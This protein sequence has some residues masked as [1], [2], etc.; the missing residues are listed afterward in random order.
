MLSTSIFFTNGL[1]MED[2]EL[3]GP[4]K[5]ES[6]RCVSFCMFIGFQKMFS[7]P[8]RFLWCWVWV[9]EQMFF[10][11][12]KKQKCLGVLR[13]H[14]RPIRTN[15]WPILTTKFENGLTNNYYTKRLFSIDYFNPIRQ[16]LTGLGVH[17]A[18]GPG[19]DW[20]HLGDLLDDV[21][22]FITT[23]ASPGCA[24]AERQNTSGSWFTK[25]QHI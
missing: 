17:W 20:A 8:W 14:P 1:H 18:L 22:G 19:P 10:F 16:P 4:W 12:K 6:W 5:F 24:I 15:I 21:I 2:A 7:G 9:V 23:L 25:A 3:I 11:Y 13:E